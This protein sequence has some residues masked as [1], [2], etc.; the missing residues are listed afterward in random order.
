MRPNVEKH[1]LNQK[2]VIKKKVE[3]VAETA[4]SV[5]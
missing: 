1:E 2:T 5:D 4:H 3:I